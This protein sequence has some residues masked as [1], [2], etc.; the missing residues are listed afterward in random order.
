MLVL[1]SGIRIQLFIQWYLKLGC[2]AGNGR[3]VHC[4]HVVSFMG[5]LY[6]LTGAATVNEYLEQWI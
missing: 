5:I 1:A 4:G 3:N 6:F 2:S